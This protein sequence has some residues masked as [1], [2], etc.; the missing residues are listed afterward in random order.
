LF[1]KLTAFSL[2]TSLILAGITSCSG[3]AD[4]KITETPTEEVTAEE[5]VYT[6]KVYFSDILK[7]SLTIEDIRALEQ[8]V[9]TTPEQDSNQEGPKL[10]SV[11][12]L[13][14]IKEFSE[15][16]VSGMTQGRIATAELTLTRTQVDDTVLLDITNRGTTKLAG[17][18]IPSGSWIRDV[19][20]L[21]VK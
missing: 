5:S 17:L 12:E 19:V 14:G 9:V 8:V 7:A 2:I 3:R 13:A 1:K 20:E 4:S 15:V 10:L 18:N 16:K 21:R 6:I 11:L